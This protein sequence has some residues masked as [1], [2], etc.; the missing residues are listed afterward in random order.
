MT[1]DRPFAWPFG[2]FFLAILFAIALSP[3]LLAAAPFLSCVAGR[4]R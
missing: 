4:E 1:T 2:S 3:V